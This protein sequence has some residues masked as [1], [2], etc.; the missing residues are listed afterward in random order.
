LRTCLNGDG[1]RIR[2]IKHTLPECDYAIATDCIGR[3]LSPDISP[4]KLCKYNLNKPP[5][6][7][8][9]KVS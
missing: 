8:V 2:E 7:A 6:A 3:N 5:A 9:R 1:Q 4:E